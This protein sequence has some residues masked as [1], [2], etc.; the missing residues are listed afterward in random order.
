[1]KKNLSILPTQSLIYCFICGAGII[2]FIFLI[3]IP[4]Q[5]TSAELD[6]DIE[7][8]NDR[9]EEQRILRPVFDSLLKRAKK[10]YP[11]DLPATQELKLAHGDINE[12]SDLLQEIA[13][14]HDLEMKDIRTDVAAL[15]EK[16]GNMLMQIDLTGDFMQFRDF[17]MD[18][19]TIYSLEQIEEIKIRAIEGAREFNLRIRMAQKW[20]DDR[21]QMVETEKMSFDSQRATRN[22]Q[23]AQRATRNAQHVT[24]NTQRATRNAQH[25]T[26]NS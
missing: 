17:L 11:I 21:R 5:K 4:S 13:R 14:R 16:S 3:I 18:L 25:V 20:S 6:R 23:H 19:S 8:I 15:M 9:I 1:M 7:K 24:R 2:V 26:R 10:E 12:I 22:A